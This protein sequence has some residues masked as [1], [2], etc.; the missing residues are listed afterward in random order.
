MSWSCSCPPLGCTKVTKRRLHTAKRPYS[1]FSSHASCPHCT[2]D[3][4]LR[5]ATTRGGAFGRVTSRRRAPRT[6]LLTCACDDIIQALSR[7]SPYPV[8]VPLDRVAVGR[9]SLALHPSN[10]RTNDSSNP[11]R[12][13]HRSKW[14]DWITMLWTMCMMSVPQN[15]VTLY[16]IERVCTLTVVCFL[17][18]TG[19]RSVI[20]RGYGQ[21]M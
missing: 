2:D 8:P 18:S 11:G 21:Q 10:R 13:G 12:F 20:T 6:L 16:C 17:L 5:F 4:T 1:T 19:S 7:P 3:A 15:S 14:Y 9:S